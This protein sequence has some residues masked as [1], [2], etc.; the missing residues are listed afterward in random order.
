MKIRIITIM[1]AMTAC[2]SS[3]AQTGTGINTQ[4]PQGLFHIDGAKDNPGTGAPSAVQQANDVIVDVQGNVGIGTI[5][6]DA[7]LVIIGTPT[8]AAIKATNIG[9]SNLAN[10]VDNPSLVPLVIDD[11]GI[12]YKQFSPTMLEN[13]YA[14][15][16]TYGVPSGQYTTLFTAITDNTI[17]LFEFHTNFA[18]GNSN[19]GIVYGAISYSTKN[20]F[21]VREWSFSGNTSTPGSNVTGAGTNT[22][23]IDSNG[24]ADIIFQYTG[25][26]IRVRKSVS[27]TFTLYLYNGKK[28]R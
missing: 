13:S 23:T 24:G 1:L 14:S 11:Q 2:F 7:K 17:V 26:I 6:P 4:N 12:M 9:V 5:T 20:G 21:Q 22:L 18:F 19:T 16:A 25:G 8:T 10:N 27:Q 28:I 3:N 15:E